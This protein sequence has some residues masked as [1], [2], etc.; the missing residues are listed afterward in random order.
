MN[1][2]DKLV[3]N[4]LLPLKN[5]TFKL[6]NK[7]F[8]KIV[9]IKFSPKN[10]FLMSIGD[11]IEIFLE[12]FKTI[13]ETLLEYLDSEENIDDNF[14][15]LHQLF[16]DSKIQECQ[17]DFRLFLHLLLKVVNNRHRCP[18]FF[19][20]IEFCNSSKMISPNTKTMTYSS[21]LRAASESSFSLLKKKY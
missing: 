1:I 7:T 3:L 10:P 8:K 12:K 19:S 11:S 18:D 6:Q 4:S 20:K 9:I 2:Q 13:Q 5:A 17:H 21:F 15:T 16:K 14:Q